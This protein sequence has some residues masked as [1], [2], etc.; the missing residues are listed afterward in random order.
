[1]LQF[2]TALPNNTAPRVNSSLSTAG[3]YEILEVGT[4]LEVRHDLNISIVPS[5]LIL[6][7]YSSEITFL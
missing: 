1:M 6:L 4:T 2:L 3:E 5:I 7:L